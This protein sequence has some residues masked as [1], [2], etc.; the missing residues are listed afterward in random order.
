MREVKFTKFQDP[1]RAPDDQD[2]PFTDEADWAFSRQEFLGE[3]LK[4]SPHRGSYFFSQ[5][6]GLLALGDNNLPSRRHKMWN[7]HTNFVLYPGDIAAING[8]LGVEGFRQLTPY[9][10]LFS[11]GWMFKDNEVKGWVREA[12]CPLVPE[13][14]A[15][16]EDPLLRAA[17]TR[18]RAWAVVRLP[19]Q[20][21][22]VVGGDSRESVE[23]R[24]SGREVLMTSWGD[25]Q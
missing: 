23:G 10:F 9:Q 17:T 12:L 13:A 16:P 8:T 14:P 3:N 2:D 18:Y 4:P 21:R 11:V 25:A 6:V 1:F 7:G 24:L 19:N 20:K 22:D 5:Y 15:L